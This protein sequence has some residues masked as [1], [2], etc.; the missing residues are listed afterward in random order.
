[1]ESVV[2]MMVFSPQ[3]RP[4]AIKTTA[5]GEKRGGL[6]QQ[7]HR[8]VMGPPIAPRYAAPYITDA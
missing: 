2:G 6:M 1:V 4:N 3:D 5:A 7:C 8:F